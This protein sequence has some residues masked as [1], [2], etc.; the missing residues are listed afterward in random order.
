[1]NKISGF[2]EFLYALPSYYISSMRENIPPREFIEEL[3]KA[4]PGE[5]ENIEQIC[6]LDNESK[7]IIPNT[8]IGCIIGSIAQGAALMAGHYYLLNREIDERS[9]AVIGALS[10]IP[11]TTNIISG[12]KEWKEYKKRLSNSNPAR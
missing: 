9:L 8:L 1:M 10:I 3:K 5:A 2:F 4:L 6:S 7:L 11:V 12:I